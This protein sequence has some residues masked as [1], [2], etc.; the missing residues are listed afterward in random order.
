MF[1]CGVYLKLSCIIMLNMNGKWEF[2]SVKVIVRLRGMADPSKTRNLNRYRS[3]EC[4]ETWFD[5]DTDDF[6]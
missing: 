1:G 5:G 4:S 6:I 2:V 3:V